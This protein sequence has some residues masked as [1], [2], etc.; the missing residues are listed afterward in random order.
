MSEACS[1]TITKEASVLNT[2]EPLISI[3]ASEMR[4]LYTYAQLEIKR[5]QLRRNNH[6]WS[7]FDISVF[8]IY[9][10][11][12]GYAHIILQVIIVFIYS[13]NP[14]H[15]FLEALKNCSGNY[16]SLSLSIYI[17]THI[18]IY[19]YTCNKIEKVCSVQLSDMFVTWSYKVFFFFV[20]VL[21]AIWTKEG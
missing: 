6:C 15:Q 21:L 8:S 2:H 1:F 4:I 20:F 5:Y 18:Y 17:Y 11:F 3:P 12:C 16:L 10:I 13:F 7:L 9:L 19:I 14:F